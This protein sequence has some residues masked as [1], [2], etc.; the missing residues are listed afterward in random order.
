M[1]PTNQ[2]LSNDTT[3]SQI[4][5]RVPVPLDIRYKNSFSN[6][7]MHTKWI[8]ILNRDSFKSPIVFVGARNSFAAVFTRAPN[9]SL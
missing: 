6:Y 2:D 1:S 7:D 8:S 4:K 5:S 3:F 9:E